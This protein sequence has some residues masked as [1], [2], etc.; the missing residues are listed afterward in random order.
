VQDIFGEQ[1]KTFFKI[2]ASLAA[3]PFCQPGAINKATCVRRLSQKRRRCMDIKWLLIE[4]NY[5]DKTDVI[6]F[7]VQSRIRL[8]K[9]CSRDFDNLRD[10]I[11]SAY[12]VSS[13]YIS[14]VNPL[15]LFK[16][17][18]Q[19]TKL[20]GNSDGFISRRKEPRGNRVAY[21]N[22]YKRYP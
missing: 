8:C 9:S 13:A 14:S 16:A 11:S 18:Y 17:L 12:I 20:D 10:S 3:I 19:I 15:N 6:Q 22:G 21:Q 7:I 1:R 5:T 2:A 4:D